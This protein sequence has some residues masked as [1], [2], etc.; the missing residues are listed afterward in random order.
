VTAILANPRYTGRQV[1]NR[2]RTDVDLVDPGNTGLGHKQVL[3]WNLWVVIWLM[4]TSFR[5]GARV[6]HKIAARPFGR[7]DIS[8]DELRVWCSLAWFGQFEN[9]T[10]DLVGRA[11]RISH[12]Q[13]RYGYPV[14]DRRGSN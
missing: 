11:Q 8:T 13:R 4:P 9:V 10:I 1:W 6:G 3:R 12:E 5:V 14:A 7:L 2:Q